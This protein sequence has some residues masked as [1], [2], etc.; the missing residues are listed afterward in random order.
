MDGLGYFL[1]HM[2]RSDDITL[3]TLKGHLLVEEQINMV[4]S[5]RLR[6]PKELFSARLN[7]SQRLAVLRAVSGPAA[8]L[9][10]RFS[11]YGKLNQLR[12]KLAHNLDPAEL[13]ALATEFLTELEEP[14][15]TQEFA[16]E[17]LGKRMKRC[18]ALLCGELSGC[19]EAVRSLQIQPDKSV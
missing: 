11:A 7:F 1:K 10:H 2:P 3:V 6:D 19:N 8:T 4:L 17:K 18:I 15:Y 16:K 13:E 9:S 5:M 12:N 14:G